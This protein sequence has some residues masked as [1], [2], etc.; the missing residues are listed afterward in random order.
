MRSRSARLIWLMLL[1]GVGFAAGFFVWTRN[2][3]VAE[4]RVSAERVDTRIDRA[5]A[6]VYQLGGAQHSYIA[7]DRREREFARV[8]LLLQQLANEVKAFAPSAR[9]AEARARLEALTRSAGLLAELDARA[10]DNIGLGQSL[11]AAD[12]ILSGSRST[13]DGMVAGLGEMRRVERADREIERAALFDQQR[14]ALI[15]AG[16]LWA[17]GL[18]VFATARPQS[19]QPAANVAQVSV[20][21]VALEATA[22]QRPV[23]DIEAAAEVCTAM[24][25]AAS[26]AAVPSLLSRAASVL[27]A[28]GAMLWLS[29]GDELRAVAA[30]GYPHGLTARLPA[31][32]PDA[33]NA[34]ATAWRTG[35][36]QTVASGANTSGAVVAPLLGPDSC[37][38]ALAI[39]VRP[40][41]ELDAV[42]AAVTSM[43]AAHLA[44][45]VTASS[46]AASSQVSESPE[47]TF[48]DAETSSAS[49]NASA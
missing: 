13:L 36:L 12:L 35:K 26:V 28:A 41:R 42:A 23:I 1:L 39:E 22:P 20:P 38:G 2:V 37:V 11:I 45:L 29:E 47:P 27:E 16:V 44:S 48:P 14:L 4:L 31:L 33:D 9:S 40:G 19:I 15:I 17:A 43:F 34:T 21:V 32:G 5:I 25:R 46:S 10:R 24:S 7:P 49:L 6:L 8:S 18:I 30:H 3:L